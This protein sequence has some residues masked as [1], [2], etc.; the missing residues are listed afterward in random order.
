MSVYKAIAEIQSELSKIGISK[1]QTNRQQGF[2]FRGIDDVYSALSPLL[3]KH[4]LVI[5]PRVLNRYETVRQTK[6]GGLLYS[7][8]V[9]VEYTFVATEDGSSHVCTIIAEAM[10]SADKATNKAMSA[11]YK[12]LGLQAFCIPTEGESPDMDAETHPETKPAPRISRPKAQKYIKSIEDA[13]SNEDGLGLREL[14]DELK[15]DEDLM[16]H[17]WNYFSTEQKSNAKSL[18]H[19]ARD[20]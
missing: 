6:N 16:R 13:L 15:E 2:K 5:L 19:E 1:D 14:N 11:A 9:E 8:V 18:L 4:G 10:D 20:K 7:V 12:Y 17:V 3:A